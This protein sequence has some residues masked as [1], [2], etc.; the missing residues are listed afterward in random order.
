[1]A[2]IFSRELMFC[3][4]WE[5]KS[6]VEWLFNMHKALDSEPNSKNIKKSKIEKKE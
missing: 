1:M 4:G 5:C 2:H 6:G 3:T